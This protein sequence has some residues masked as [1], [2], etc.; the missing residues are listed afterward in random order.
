MSARDPDTGQFVSSGGRGEDDPYLNTD[1]ILSTNTWQPQN[2][3]NFT[4]DQVNGR[5]AQ[6]TVEIDRPDDY[7]IEIHGFQTHVGDPVADGGEAKFDMFVVNED[8]A[9]AQQVGWPTFERESDAI[10]YSSH[11][12]AVNDDVNGTGAAWTDENPAG[13]YPKPI[14]SSGKLGIL[15][16]TSPSDAGGEAALSVHYTYR[17]F[18]DQQILRQLIESR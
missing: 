11:V 6:Q 10:I 12:Q 16:R 17:E 15:F 5:D 9:P 18:D 8:E 3:G 7:L 2:G 4:F 14:L 1:V 13:Y